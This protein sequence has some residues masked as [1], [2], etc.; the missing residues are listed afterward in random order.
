MSYSAVP[1]IDD[2]SYLNR[3]YGGT[4]QHGLGI[5]DFSDASGGVHSERR[6]R[7]EENFDART[8]GS[9]VL[10]GDLPQRSSSRAST[11]NQG[12]APSRSGTLK[13]KGSV[14]RT[15]SLKRS[16]SRR[17]LHA[18][19]IRG[20]AI[21][22]QEQGYEREQSIFYTPVPTKGSPTDILAERFQTWRKF[23]KDLIIYFREVASSYEHRA[24]SLLKVSNVINNTNAPAALL[25]EGGLNDANRILRD[26]H[27]QTITEANKARDIEADVINQLSGLR[28]DL[29]QKIKEIK[30]LSGDFK[31]SVEK[32]KETTRKCVAA[33]EEAL[34][35]VDSDPAAAAGKGDPYVVGLGVE[36]QVEKQIDEENYLHRAYLN[37]ENSGRELESI[38]VGEIQK[39]YN[40]LASILKRDADEMYNT[41]ENLRSGP[42]TMPRD[43]EWGR[44][45]R[46]DP[47][48]VN[49]DI[50][51]RRLEDIEY[52]GKHHPATTEVRA[53]MLE[54]KSKY[55]KS[56]TP[57]WYVLSPTHIHEFKSADRIYSQPPVMSLC[58]L[59][60]KLGSKSQPGSSSHKF[61][62]K[63]RQTGT[64]HRGHT[65]VFRAETYETMQAWYD[66]IKTLTEK[67]GEERNAFVRRH[68]SVR[69]TSAAS[70]RSASSDGGLEEDEADAI[71]YSAAP[72]VTN[73]AR[74]QSSQR[75]P[76]PSPGGRFPSD[77]NVNRNLQVPLSPSSGSSEVGDDI[78]TG[79]GDKH[80]GVH[81]TYNPHPAAYSPTRFDSHGQYSEQQELHVGSYPSMQQSF[82]A[83]HAPVA[84]NH[85]EM[86]SYHQPPGL[87]SASIGRHD[88]S[89]GSWMA[90]AV[91]GA[92]SGTATGT[93]ATKS[94]YQQEIKQQ[95]QDGKQTLEQKSIP[96]EELEHYPVGGATALNVAPTISERN[97]EHIAPESLPSPV[98]QANAPS[99]V[100]VPIPSET[101]RGGSKPVQL[102]ETADVVAQPRVARQNTD[103]S[104]SELHV[105]GEYPK[106]VRGRVSESVVPQPL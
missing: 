71:P 100:S 65:W 42:I 68:A 48:F 96:Q 78:I 105:P 50:P 3:G 87:D 77:L 102:S 76:R 53:G 79:T 17:S 46:S 40:A 81:S 83:S 22:D 27:K 29:A 26:F 49:P 88:S 93:T 38:V 90:P 31:N 33:L 20:V 89:H 52:P 94:S 21:D 9:S 104:A 18:G 54:R 69:S 60:Q 56:Y 98:V 8:R 99:P 55:L 43:H 92:V 2:P 7:F 24:K 70:A 4:S 15:G 12:S 62:I 5:Q 59:D 82:D 47:H 39:A 72:S 34:A 36:R 14:K 80:E 85:Q 67:T 10:D 63:G 61:V 11:L 103:V 6:G 95:K 37:L 86:H 58:L 25:I 1:D 35:V 16:G 64:M 91:G 23:L 32:E 44:F 75:P 19:S 45:V 84:Q 30:S 28:A 73:H 13:K 101:V 106:G 74:D 41:V 57:G 51:L 66:D 97:P